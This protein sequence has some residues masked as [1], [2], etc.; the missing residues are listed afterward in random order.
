[1]WVDIQFLDTFA[2]ACYKQ[3]CCRHV[4]CQWLGVCYKELSLGKRNVVVYEEYHTVHALAKCLA[5]YGKEHAGVAGEESLIKENLSA[6]HDGTAHFCVSLQVILCCYVVRAI[7]F[8]N[9]YSRSFLFYRWQVELLLFLSLFQYRPV[10]DILVRSD[11]KC[12]FTQMF[13]G[14]CQQWLA[15][16]S[17]GYAAVTVYSV[18]AEYLIRNGAFDSADK[19]STLGVKA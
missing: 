2:V 8:K 18:L 7:L 3:L 6:A 14:A 10:L 19:M 16:G 17:N 13:G 1:M 4:A 9:L 12:S 15:V 5:V 11:D